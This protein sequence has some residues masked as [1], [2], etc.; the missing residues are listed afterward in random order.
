MNLDSNEVT[1]EFFELSASPASF[2]V[3]LQVFD[4]HRFQEVDN[5]LPQAVTQQGHP[6]FLN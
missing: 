3:K 4:C 2:A 6:K 1:A 5:T